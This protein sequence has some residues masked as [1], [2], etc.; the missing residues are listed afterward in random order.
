MLLPWLQ[1]L[2]SGWW[3]KGVSDASAQKGCTGPSRGDDLPCMS[4]R[5]G[6]GARRG[7][8]QLGRQRLRSAQMEGVILQLLS[9]CMYARATSLTLACKKVWL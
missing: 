4:V 6:F 8:Q 9:K 7:L 2:G 1:W 5:G 3:V